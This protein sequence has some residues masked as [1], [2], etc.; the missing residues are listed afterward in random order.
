MTQTIGY[1]VSH[2]HHSNVILFFRQV[3]LQDC[4]N[5]LDKIDFDLSNEE[6]WD[7]LLV[8]EPITWRKTKPNDDMDEDEVKMVEIQQEKHLDMPIPWSMA[9]SIPHDGQFNVNEV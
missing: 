9:I 1:F 2:V 8:G 6:N 3:N 7:H 5:G 4:S